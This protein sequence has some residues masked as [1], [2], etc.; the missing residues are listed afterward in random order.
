MAGYLLRGLAA[1]IFI[2]LFLYLGSLNLLQHYFCFSG[3]F[4]DEEV[5]RI[6]ELQ[7]Y[8]ADN[9]ISAADSRKLKKWAKERNI[10]EFT[11][12]REEWLVF[13]FSYTEEVSP[14]S[15][16][17]NRQGWKSY[18]TVIFQDGKADVYIY[19]GYDKKYYYALFVVSVIAGVAVCIGI[20]IFGIREDITYIQQLKKEIDI[21]SVGNLDKSVTIKGNDEI[22]QLAYG[23]D[24]MRQ[25]L[26]EKKQLENELRTAQEKLVLGM[27]HDLRTPLTG[28]I[29]YMEILKKQEQEGRASR[30]YIDKAYDKIFL[31]KNLSDQMFEYFFIDSHK[32]DILEAPEE[33]SSAIGD[34][35]SE[36]CAMLE[37]SGFLADIQYLE[38]RPVLIQVNID[39]IG[40][41]INNIISN[42][43]KYG[44]K[45]QDVQIGII[46]RQDWI[47]VYI[48]NGIAVPGSYVEG[49]GIGLRNIALMMKQMGGK[50]EKQINEKTFVL[51]LY[52]PVYKET[53]K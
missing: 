16:E 10:L 41:I 8:V 40:R 30:E 25:K 17:I 9:R 32:E 50:S 51:K 15:I 46:Y 47:C 1:G 43:E 49:T 52:F 5:N 11:I 18:Y 34:Y 2:I 31:I 45:K 53:G 12:S 21:I 24:Q 6:K 19:E 35:L 26:N 3:Y 4:R 44:D 33:V 13:N 48:E 22:S 39:Y 28:L 38:W 14:G 37:Y 29:T 20:F 7:R 23:L 36:L 27:S 42:L